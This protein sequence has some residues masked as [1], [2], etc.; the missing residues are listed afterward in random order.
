MSKT[1]LTQAQIY[2][3]QLAQC[4]LHF[5]EKIKVYQGES[6]ARITFQVIGPDHAQ[7]YER[8]TIPRFGN[9]IRMHMLNRRF[10][11]NW[12]VNRIMSEDLAKAFITSCAFPM[13][14]LP[15]AIS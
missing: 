11:G 13:D 4:Q 7:T 9:M 15:K 8:L 14:S 3:N 2:N 1:K 6:G 5:P 12:A 10:P